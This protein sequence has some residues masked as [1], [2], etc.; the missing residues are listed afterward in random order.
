M[1]FRLDR[2]GGAVFLQKSMASLLQF[3]GIEILGPFAAVF[4]PFEAHF[5]FVVGGTG[6]SGCLCL[7]NANAFRY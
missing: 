2:F 1:H 4:G 7:V 6:D 5:I 3:V